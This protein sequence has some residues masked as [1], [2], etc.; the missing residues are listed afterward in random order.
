MRKS[1]FT[2]YFAICSTVVIIS[3]TLLGAIMMVVA[4]QYFKTEKYTLLKNNTTSAVTFTV[5]NC[6]YDSDSK[7][8][9]IDPAVQNTYALLAS[10]IDAQLI[11]VESNGKANLM[12]GSMRGDGGTTEAFGGFSAYTVSEKI[13]SRMLQVGEYFEVGTLGGIYD[14]Q[15]YTYGLPIRLDN[16]QLVGFLFASPPATAM[17][18]FVLQ[19][20]QMF[21]L[22][23]VFVIFLSFIVFYIITLQLVKPL[24]RMAFAAKKFGSGDFSDRIEVRGEDE[25]AELALALNNMA[26]S[27]SIIE[28]TRR[29]F[30]A[31]VSHELR[32]PMTTI[33][34]F[35]DGVLDG[36]IPKE[37]EREYLTIVSD[38]VKRLSRLVRAMLNMSRLES[39]EVKI[40][41]T[42]FDLLDIILQTLFSF[43]TVIE[44]KRVSIEGLDREKVIV[45]A[46]KDLIHQVVYNLVENAVKFVDEGGTISFDFRV[47]SGKIHVRI[48]N[49]GAGLSR[50]EVR[51]VFERFYKSDKSRSLDT[52]GV[53][54][55]LYIVRSIISL[56]GGEIAVR[57]K[58]GE[59]CEFEFYI[60]AGR[61]SKALKKGNKLEENQ[62]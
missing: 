46:D 15:Y 26:Q 42:N 35:V 45:E 27:L 8:A 28:S 54:L 48:R 19:V 43:E 17:T 5:D 34:G 25:I 21:C 52:N 10:A 13:L 31:N 57:S 61:M 16:G 41:K 51:H 9:T 2:K 38:E 47:E 30:V 7:T 50:E 24:R 56:H 12:V 62:G 3:L 20:L 29:S 55:G 44:S 23:S 59:Y 36:T 60:P 18:E 22:S 1:L 58:E 32:T 11:L 14:S 4:G 6:V 49:S 39:G 53:G 33:S 40:T 37:K